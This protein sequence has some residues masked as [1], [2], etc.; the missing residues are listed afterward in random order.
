MQKCKQQLIYDLPTRFFHWIFVLFFI[1]SFTIAKT[2]DDDNPIF[3]YHMILGLML[4]VLVL[5]RI[6]WGVIGTRY[7]RF[8]SFSL[9]PRDLVSYLKDVFSN[10]K[11][12]WPGHNPASSWAALIMICSALLLAISGILMTTGYKESFEDIHEF[13]AN[14]FLITSLFHILGVFFHSFKYQ[15]G[16]LFTMFHGNKELDDEQLKISHSHPFFAF[17]VIIIIGL[18]GSYLVNH[19]NISNHQLKIFG[20]T[21]FLE[22]DKNQEKKVDKGLYQNEL[23]ED[24]Y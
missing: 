23:Y 16:I 9:H 12:L 11:R 1:S 20:K 4:G 8:S 3:F 13:L 10:K 24:D 7:A 15:D 6:L 5:L 2:I 22:S 19:Y 18:S 17:L 14:A 21:L